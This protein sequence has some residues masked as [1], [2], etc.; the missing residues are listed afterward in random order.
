MLPLD[1]RMDALNAK[2]SCG[3]KPG[4]EMGDQPSSEGRDAI[5]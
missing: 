1:A 3:I 4:L 5:F 2:C